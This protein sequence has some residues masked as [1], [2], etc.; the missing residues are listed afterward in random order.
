MPPAGLDKQAAFAYNTILSAGRSSAWLERYLGVVEAA[1][2]SL[3]APT[4]Q[5]VLMGFVRS[6]RT[7]FLFPCLRRGRFRS[8]AGA[9]LLQAGPLLLSAA[10]RRQNNLFFFRFSLVF[11]GALWYYT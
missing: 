5:S 9:F 2:S 3:V 11:L 1:S 7:L 10:R 4:S 8:A 6:V